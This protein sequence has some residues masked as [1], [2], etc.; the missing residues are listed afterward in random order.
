MSSSKRRCTNGSEGFSWGALCCPTPAPRPGT[1]S[2]QTPVWTSRM[3]ASRCHCREKR[4]RR[5]LL[6]A[7]TGL[8][9][10]GSAAEYLIWQGKGSCRVLSA[11]PGV[12]LPLVL[13]TRGVSPGLGLGDDIV[14]H[15]VDHCPSGEAQGVGEEGLC[16]H[17]G[18][19]T[20]D[21]S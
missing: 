2:P 6:A 10:E 4:G 7:G 8:L 5:E 17:H 9:G 21:A 15:H 13:V 18:E 16:H 1:S 11:S 19:G 20:E 3:P 12:C 14:H